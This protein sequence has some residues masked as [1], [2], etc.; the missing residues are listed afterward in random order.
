MTQSDKNPNIFVIR[1]ENIG[2]SNR[3][4]Y[5]H[6]IRSLVF[7]I[8]LAALAS[9]ARA[10]DTKPAGRP[11]K[12]MV[13]AATITATVEAIDY[14]RRTIALKGPRGNILVTK[15]G[16]DVKNFKQIKTGDQVTAKYYEATAIYVRKPDEPPFAQKERS[17]QVAAPGERPAAVAVDTTELR[18]RVEDIDYKNRTVTLRAPQQKTTTIKVS[19]EVKR[20]DEV[21]KGDEIVVRH[22]EAVAV[23]VEPAAR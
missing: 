14:D 1:A 12:V 21:K 6:A 11:G 3:R 19:K 9:E 4:C 17:V 5:L 20:F 8:M 7:L 15:V 16:P 18:A 23:N 13:D 22:T 2:I 10:Q